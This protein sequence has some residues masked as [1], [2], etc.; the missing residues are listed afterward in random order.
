MAII[1]VSGG[2]YSGGKELAERLS[3]KLGYR[4]VTQEK[5]LPHEAAQLGIPED[6]PETALSEKF[7]LLGGSGLRRVFYIAYMQVAMCEDS[8]VD[9]VVYHGQVAHL[10]LRGIPHHIGIRVV[11]DMEH[12]IQAAMKYKWFTRERAMEFIKSR[13]AERDKWAKVIY[14]ANRNDPSQHDI[15][16]NAGRLEVKDACDIIARTVNTE[17]RTTQESLKSIDDLILAAELRARIALERD[18]A[19][20][21]VEVD[22]HDGIVILRGTVNSSNDADRIRILIRQHTGVQDI[23]SHMG[24]R[25]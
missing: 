21:Q 22:V 12:R 15:V 11:A 14:N 6:E 25:W 8:R 16:F 23:E 2:T 7:A 17:I 3:E 24:V 5:L 10:L 13:D 20:D 19:Y 18:I 1:T 9:G 4:F